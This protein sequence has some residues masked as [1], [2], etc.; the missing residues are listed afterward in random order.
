[1]CPESWRLAGSLSNGAL[2]PL[3]STNYSEMLSS[4]TGVDA[5]PPLRPLGPH[6]G[7]QRQKDDVRLLGSE[8][9]LIMYRLCEPPNDPPVTV[10]FSRGDLAGS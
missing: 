5:P 1:M 7:G 4:P 10:G 8:P 6:M 9:Q 2:G 3:G